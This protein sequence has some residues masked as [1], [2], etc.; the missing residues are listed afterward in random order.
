M[1]SVPINLALSHVLRFGTQPVSFAIGGRYRA[2]TLL[3]DR[4]GECVTS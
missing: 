1:W 3:T 4:A 2:V